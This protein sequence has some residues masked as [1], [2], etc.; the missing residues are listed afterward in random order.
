MYLDYVSNME[1][2]SLGLTLPK[3]YEALLSLFKENS[4]Y[5]LLIRL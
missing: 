1:P 4:T 5:T 2:L 3:K